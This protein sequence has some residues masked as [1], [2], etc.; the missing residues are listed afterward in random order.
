MVNSRWWWLWVGEKRKGEKG[1][2]VKLICS[3]VYGHIICHSLSLE[4]FE[5]FNVCS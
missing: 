5:L 2:G 1:G 4:L 3:A